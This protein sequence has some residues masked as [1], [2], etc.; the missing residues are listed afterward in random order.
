MTCLSGSVSSSIPNCWPGWNGLTIT[1]KEF[2]SKG[3][4]MLGLGVPRRSA[5]STKAFTLILSSRSHSFRSFSGNPLLRWMRALK[6]SLLPF[7]QYTHGLS[8]MLSSTVK[9]SRGM[10][11]KKE[12]Q[13]LSKPWPS[14]QQYNCIESGIRPT[15]F[16]MQSQPLLFNL[17]VNVPLY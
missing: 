4:Y 10:E 13:K 14:T 11:K 8:T 3:L 12:R 6:L 2:F 16:H 17:F 15:N 7:S 9:P 5:L 1:S